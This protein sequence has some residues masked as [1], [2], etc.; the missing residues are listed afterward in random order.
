MIESAEA[1]V[2]IREIAQAGQGHLD[3]LLFAAEDCGYNPKGE[4]GL[5]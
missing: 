4:K 5:R 3:A 2:G 1:M